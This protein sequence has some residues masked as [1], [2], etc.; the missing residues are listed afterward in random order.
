[1][2]P[3]DISIRP[4]VAADYP[5]LCRLWEELDEHHRLARPDI[6]QIPEGPR[7]EHDWVTGLIDGADSEILVAET[8]AGDLV[9]MATLAVEQPPALPF[10]I[11][12]PF[13]EIHNLVVSRDF[14]RRGVATRLVRA[15]TEWAAAQAV[16]TVELGVNEFNSDALRFYEAVGFS[17]AR[18]RMSLSIPPPAVGG[19]QSPC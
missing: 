17:T 8:S 14:H 5:A 11:P 3:P 6:F 12:R 4:A 19:G 15:S 9:G 1:M 18:R 7:R 13:V 16:R 10:L 2:K